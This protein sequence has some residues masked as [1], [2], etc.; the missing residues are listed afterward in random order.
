MAAADYDDVVFAL[1]KHRRVGGTVDE[2][3]IF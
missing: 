2:P 1:V 3:G